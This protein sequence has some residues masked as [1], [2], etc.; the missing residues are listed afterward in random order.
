MDYN[1]ETQ[2][3]KYQNLVGREVE[4]F[5]EGANNT[6]IINP[7]FS[8]LNQKIKYVGK[9][10]YNHGQRDLFGYIEKNQ[11]KLIMGSIKDVNK[12]K[13]E[14][15]DSAFAPE[16]YLTSNLSEE[17]LEICRKILEGKVK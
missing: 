14:L 4:L 2:K 9:L 17:N 5:V 13:V 6:N 1:I 15:M 3:I 16:F 7:R 8:N 10:K 11:V 12:N